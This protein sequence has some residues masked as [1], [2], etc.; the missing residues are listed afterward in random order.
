MA[1]TR[2]IPSLQTLAGAAKARDQIF[3]SCR[4]SLQAKRLAGKKSTG[5]CQSGTSCPQYPAAS[6]SL[7]N[8]KWRRFGIRS[9]VT[10]VVLC[11]ASLGSEEMPSVRGLLAPGPLLWSPK[12]VDSVTPV[13]RLRGLLAA[14]SLAES[15][16]NT[17]HGYF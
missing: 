1:K 9:C 11:V 6:T 5:Y 17:T 4:T 3:T 7:T 2:P 8:K 12:E 15:C 13:D 16:L 14:V 10:T